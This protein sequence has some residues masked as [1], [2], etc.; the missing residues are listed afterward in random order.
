MKKARVIRK[1]E[2]HPFRYVA[3]VLVILVLFLGTQISSLADKAERVKKDVLE[4]GEAYF[5]AQSRN[6]RLK[7]EVDEINTDAFVERTARRDF[8]Y[9]WYGETIYTVVNLNEVEESLNPTEL[10]VYHEEAAPETV[11]TTDGTEELSAPGSES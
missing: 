11:E 1:K 7:T 6:N 10:Q 2:A 9:C 5:N 4:E 8:G 3:I